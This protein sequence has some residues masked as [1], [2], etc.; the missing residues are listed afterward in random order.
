VLSL[1][2]VLL[3]RFSSF[4]LFFLLEV[5]FKNDMRYINSRFTLLYFTFGVAVHLQ[6][7][8]FKFELQDH[9]QGHGKKVK[10]SVQQFV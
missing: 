1:E 3:F 7:I 4:R 5:F 6:H 9:G 8:R 10:V 2:H